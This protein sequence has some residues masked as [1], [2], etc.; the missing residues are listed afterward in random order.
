MVWSYSA[1]G[2]FSSSSLMKAAM[3]IRISKK[4][5]EQM[6]F[7]LWSGLAPPKVEML[8]WRIY[9]ESLPSKLSLRT[10]RVL[11]REED[12][13]CKLC[14]SEQESA[15]H[16]LLHC[17]WSWKLWSMCLTWWGSCWVMP[18]T[19]K[20]LLECWVV[21]GTSRSYKRLWKTFGYA[22]M[23]SIWEER[24]KRCFQNKKRSAEKI[25]DLIKVRL[26]WWSKYRSSKCPYSVSTISRCIEEVRDSF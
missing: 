1:D 25:G 23:W 15:N 19:A 14:D 10:R 6:P 20:S 4:K 7:Q 8:I 26:A 3:A 2:K 9:L 21:E 12:L 13:V 11:R 18:E 5:W 17:K 22:I 24:N 16:L